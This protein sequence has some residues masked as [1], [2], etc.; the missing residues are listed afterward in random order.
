MNA[1][2]PGEHRPSPPTAP[3]P[4]RGSS[5]RTGTIRPCPCG[6]SPDR[7]RHAA[8]QRG[9]L[10]YR[11]V[12][13]QSCCDASGWTA[14]TPARRRTE[15]P[16]TRTPSWSGAGT[17]T[18]GRRTHLP[19]VR[20]EGG[21]DSIVHYDLSA[22]VRA[23]AALSDAIVE[24]CLQARCEG[25][26]SASCKDGLACATRAACAEA[27][28]E[29]SPGLGGGEQ[30]GWTARWELPPLRGVGPAGRARREEPARLPS[31]RDRAGTLDLS[32]TA[33]DG[34]MVHRS[35]DP[36][37]A[38]L[39]TEAHCEPANRPSDGGDKRARGRRGP[40]ARRTAGA[41]GTT[42]SPGARR[43]PAYAAFRLDFDTLPWGLFNGLPAAVSKVDLS[44][45]AGFRCPAPRVMD[46][47][48]AGAELL[49]G[50]AL[51]AAPCA[52]PRTGA[53]L[54]LATWSRTPRRSSSLRG[55]RA[56]GATTPRFRR[57]RRA[58][59][60]PGAAGAPPRRRACEGRHAPGEPPCLRRLD[61]ASCE[62]GGS[63]D[64][65]PGANPARRGPGAA[66]AAR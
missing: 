33:V 19:R 29:W 4:A 47:I 61:E 59:R 13:A 45:H 44:G 38:A 12:S 41:G 10:A 31:G 37:I 3:G 32:R 60:R 1:C 6:A 18:S 21:S 55:R 51:D 15:R 35:W 58:A 34:L 22:P 48:P 7:G 5:T 62:A 65:G 20:A 8:P 25:R 16:T 64:D 42:T 56:R 40:P 63:G 27:E 17:P 50:N 53:C 43:T 26:C 11:D 54:N 52:D 39:S 24:R 28:G 57:P 30:D 9:P 66:H 14:P 46:G 23:D 2:P 36:T 49:D